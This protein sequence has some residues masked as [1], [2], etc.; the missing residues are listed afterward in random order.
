MENKTSQQ[1]IFNL[2]VT[3]EYYEA[4]YNVFKPPYTELKKVIVIS[5]QFKGD[6]THRQLLSRY[7]KARDVLRDYEFDKRHNHK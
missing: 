2:D 1:E 7:L 6:D 4:N 3:K 5:D